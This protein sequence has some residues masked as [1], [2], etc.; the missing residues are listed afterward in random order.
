[1]ALAIWT[2]T[3][4]DTHTPRGRVMDRTSVNVFAHTSNEAVVSGCAAFAAMGADLVRWMP[5]HVEMRADQ[6]L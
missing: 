1:M 3:F 4:A 5:A 2:L 6:D